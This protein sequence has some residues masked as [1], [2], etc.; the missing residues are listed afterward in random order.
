MILAVDIQSS[1]SPPTRTPWSQ[2]IM[3][4]K[5]EN[6]WICN[7]FYSF[8]HLNKSSC[9]IM[10]VRYFKN[11]FQF[12]RNHLYL[13]IKNL[14]W[15]QHHLLSVYVNK[16]PQYWKT[17]TYW[18][19]VICMYNLCII[20]E[21]LQFKNGGNGASQLVVIPTKLSPSYFVRALSKFVN[22]SRF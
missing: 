7:L 9:N 22:F 19:W 14:R 2:F 6:I 20:F 16:K 1:R 3:I 11:T 8:N 13:S 4:T 15:L 21:W 5:F 12:S 17:H 18:N 10:E